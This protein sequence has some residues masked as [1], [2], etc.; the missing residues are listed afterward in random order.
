M[1]EKHM[2]N[3]KKRKQHFLKHK[4]NHSNF[5]EAYTDRSKSTRRKIHFAAVF[6]D[7]SKRGALPE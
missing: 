6:A 2:G 7:I 1:T 4:G 3:D 5:K